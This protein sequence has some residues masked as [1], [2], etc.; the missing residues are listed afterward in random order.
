MALGSMDF[1]IISV[2][3]LN[4]SDHYGY[5]EGQDQIVCTWFTGAW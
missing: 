3:G 5:K 1:P 2:R 4:I